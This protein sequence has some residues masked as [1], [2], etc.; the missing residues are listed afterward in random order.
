VKQGVKSVQAVRYKG[1]QD[2][3]VEAA[4]PLEKPVTV[5]GNTVIRFQYYVFKASKVGY[6]FTGK[7]A[8]GDAITVNA[9]KVGSAEKKWNEIT[10]KAATLRAGM[11]AAGAGSTI[12]QLHFR[13]GFKGESP[14]LYIDNVEIANE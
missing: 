13:A 6:G 14:T 7:N 11:V 5:A 4:I 10:V 9:L 2:F 1:T 12:E 8:G 3:A